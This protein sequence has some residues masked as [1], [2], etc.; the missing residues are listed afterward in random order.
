MADDGGRLE[1]RDSEVNRTTRRLRSSSLSAP[2]TSSRSP[3]VM[4]EK[5]TPASGT[6]AKGKPARTLTATTSGDSTSIWRARPSSVSIGSESVAVPLGGHM[7]G[8]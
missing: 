4:A 2:R 3:V 1:P 6:S 8:G 5:L 7:M